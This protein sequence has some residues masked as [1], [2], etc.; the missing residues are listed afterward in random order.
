[1]ADGLKSSYELA[2]ER[3]KKKD[4]EA[5]IEAVTLTDQQKAAIAEARNF[6]DSK[7]AEQEVLYQSKMRATFDPAERETLTEMYRRDRER[8]T[9]DR[10]AKIEKE[11][12]KGNERITGYTPIPNSRFGNA[13]RPLMNGAQY[14]HF[15][16]QVAARFATQPN[17]AFWLRG[18]FWSIG[19]ID[20]T[21][22]CVI[23]ELVHRGD[24]DSVRDALQLMG[25]APPELALSRPHFAVHI[26]EEAGRVDPQLG[27]SAESVFISNA[28][29]GPFSRPSGQPS[30][31]FLSMKDRS[32]SLRDLFPQGSAGRRVFDRLHAAAVETLNREQLDDEQMDFE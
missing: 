4:A 20:A 6:Y 19:S 31:K 14:K 13:F 28:Q 15:L 23:D 32:K 24:K 27:T 26:V 30:P 9:S 10:D 16:E 29:S 17:Q 12:E 1:M 3:L 5:G 22:L 11:N 18:L 7:I 25:G 8:L 21:S 2:M